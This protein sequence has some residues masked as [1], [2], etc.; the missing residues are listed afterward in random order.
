MGVRGAVAEEAERAVLVHSWSLSVVS[1]IISPREGPRT[2]AVC[3]T[4]GGAG[5]T[6]ATTINHH[7]MMVD[8]RNVGCG[9]QKKFCSS[10]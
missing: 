3:L 7:K 5:F 2:L 10:R 8:I 6:N 4:R 1:T 9:L